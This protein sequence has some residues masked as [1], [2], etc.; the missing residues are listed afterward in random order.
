MVHHSVCLF[1]LATAAAAGPTKDAQLKP[2]AAHGSPAQ[3][4]KD[5]PVGG[6]QV[7]QALSAPA[8]SAPKAAPKA[9]PAAKVVATSEAAP[10]KPVHLSTEKANKANATQT[11]NATMA[12]A[13][14]A[15]ASASSSS[16]RS[17]TFRICNANPKDA[18]GVTAFL[19]DGDSLHTELTEGQKIAFKSCRDFTR[20]VRTGDF[21]ELRTEASKTP[22]YLPT[23]PV[24]GGSVGL[25]VVYD[26]GGKPGVYL[27]Y[28][29][30]LVNPQI[31][32]V[33]VGGG[34]TPLDLSCV[35]GSCTTGQKEQVAT[36]SVVPVYPGNYAVKAGG[37]SLELNALSGG[38]YAVLL[39]S[40]TEAMI[41][42]PPTPV[43]SGA[44]GLLSLSALLVAL[45]AA[46]F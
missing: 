27:H 38:T 22:I 29:D 17:Q 25:I 43:Y 1:L 5:T 26:K 16:A 30:Q 2:V 15:D 46:A 4:P 28:F 44:A 13:A 23:A 32:A 11:S 7:L 45:A 12:A 10:A 39:V 20:S 42:P 9:I 36:G 31:A 19:D 33:D 18:K 3:T 40:P 6:Q 37:A 41:Y 21:V 24:A 8:M 34:A 14:S 35:S